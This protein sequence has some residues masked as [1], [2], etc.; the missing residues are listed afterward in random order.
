M[1]EAAER[2][3]LLE[4][5]STSLLVGPDQLPSLHALLAD[6]A[7][8]LGISAPELYVRQSPQPNAYT[9]AVSG[10]KP[11]IVVHTALLELLEPAEV[12]AVLAHELGEGR[13]RV[14]MRIWDEQL[15][16]AVLVTAPASPQCAPRPDAP[17]APTQAT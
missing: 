4:N 3:L 11:F 8:S 1:G 6:A 7:A 15:Q 2:V 14:C 5:I 12:Q 16:H 17:R 13:Y 10:R 9:L